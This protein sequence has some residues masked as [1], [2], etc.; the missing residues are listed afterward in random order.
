MHQKRL[1][2]IFPK[3]NPDL[4]YETLLQLG[5][6]L[7]LLDPKYQTSETRVFGCQST[8][9]LH[10]KIQENKIFF[11]GFSDALITKGILQLLIT[12]FN[13]LA[14]EEIIQSNLSVLK[15]L[16]LPQILSPSRANGLNA[17]FKRMQQ[18]ALLHLVQV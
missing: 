2:E 15:E 6:K 11:E 16:N 9:F 1:A 10:S 4:I 17:I 14:P 3:Q 18:L 12:L 8:V 13:G 7:P 5:T